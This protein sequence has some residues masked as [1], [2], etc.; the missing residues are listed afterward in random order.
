MKPLLTTYALL[1]LLSPVA[2]SLPAIATPLPVALSILAD[3]LPAEVR[4]RI[5]PQIAEDQGISPAALSVVSSTAETWS[6]SCLGVPNPVE[7]CAAVLTPGW[8][9]TVTDGA[10]TWVYRTDATGEVI[11]EEGQPPVSAYT[12]ITGP[13]AP[14]IYEAL[15]RNIMVGFPGEA[16]FHPADPLTREQLATVLVNAMRQVP[17]ENPDSSDSAIAQIPAPPAEVAATAFTD[18]PPARWSA[19]SIQY[20]ADLGLIQGYPDGTFRPE[21]PV[22]R[23]ELVSLLLKMDVYLVELRRWDGRDASNLEPT[24]EFSDTQGHWAARSIA[25]MSENCRAA[26]PLEGSD[27][28]FAPNAPA[29]RAYAAAAVMRDLRCLSFLPSPDAGA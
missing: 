25:V 6:D 23:A 5:L 26:E 17:M 29:T 24:F 22:T 4:D 1:T 19:A 21:Q 12:D 13:Y 27:T 3:P 18:V 20:L 11:R 16:R 14:E 8:R 2:W 7:L 28:E 15:G 9:V 10:T